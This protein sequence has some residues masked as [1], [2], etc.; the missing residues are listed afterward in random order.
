MSATAMSWQIT[1]PGQ[2]ADIIER[3][4]SGSGLYAQEFNDFI[5]TALAD[6]ELDAYRQ[7]CEDLHGQFER[8]SSQLITLSLEEPERQA[9]RKA[10][11]IEDL[12][13]IVKELRLLQRDAQSPN[14][15]TSH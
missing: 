13:Q 9:R 6:P 2:A 7:R 8:D 11:A 5:D 3:F 10:A 15:R 1:T 4:L 12:K 14:E